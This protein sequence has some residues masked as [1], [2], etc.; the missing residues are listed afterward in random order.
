MPYV[1]EGRRDWLDE[2]VECMEK[3]GLEMDGDLNYILFK[4]AKHHVPR[5]YNNLKDFI[6]ELNECVAE[7]RRRLL[8]PYE[9]RKI[10]EN[11]DV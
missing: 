2:V 10:E 6:A 4:Y 11:G 7:V 9:D 1:R 5:S 8:A 3:K